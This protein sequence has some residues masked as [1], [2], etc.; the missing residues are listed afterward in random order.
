M[1]LI[2]PPGISERRFRRALDAFAAVVGREWVL[3]TSTDR[4]TYLDIYAPGNEEQH[5][6]SAA[7]SVESTEQ[8][9]AIVRLANEHRI[10][11]WPISRGKNFGYGGAAPRMAGSVVLDLSRMRR[12]LE[13]DERFGYCIVEPGVGFYDLY[14]HV[15]SRDLP[16][17]LSLPGNAWGSVVGNA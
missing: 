15:R 2:L 16:L 11:L 13:V 10:P 12:I 7:V 1:R 8:V 5:A 4:E 14:D 6:P 3:D 17:W 9:Q